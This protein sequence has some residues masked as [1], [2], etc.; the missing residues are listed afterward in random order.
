MQ[1]NRL[2]LPR[3]QVRETTLRARTVLNTN[4]K[5]YSKSLV[6]PYACLGSSSSLT[7]T[8]L[9]SERNLEQ[10]A[11]WAPYAV[12]SSPWLRLRACSNMQEQPLRSSRHLELTETA[13]SARAR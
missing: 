4:D 5:G 6:E 11:G 2:H 12:Y 9:A 1:L 8:T 7:R 3:K 10:K 13:F